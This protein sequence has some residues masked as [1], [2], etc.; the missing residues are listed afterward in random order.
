MIITHRYGDIKIGS[1]SVIE[2]VLGFPT[3]KAL[4]SYDHCIEIGAYRKLSKSNEPYDILHMPRY[5]I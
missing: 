3:E 5:Y 4:V 2:S 1:T